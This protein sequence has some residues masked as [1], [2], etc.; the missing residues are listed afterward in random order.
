MLNMAEVVPIPRAKVKTAAAV[1]A[2]FLKKVRN[3]KRR[4]RTNPS[5]QSSLG[6]KTYKGLDGAGNKGYASVRGLVDPV[7]GGVASLREN[8]RKT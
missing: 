2:G 5:I 7:E 3:A 8:P 6:Q 1:K 4:S